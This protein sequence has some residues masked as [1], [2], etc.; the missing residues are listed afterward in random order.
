M[1]TYRLDR[2]FAPRSVALVGASPRPTSPGR[3]VLRNL[4]QAGFAGPIH[5]INPHY[6]EIEGVRAVRSLS[7]L[8]E[9]PDAI[10]IAAPP[11]AVPQIVAEA[12]EKGVAAGIIITSGLGHGPGSLAAS[13]EAAARR[14]GV[15]LVGPNCLGVL[16]P[17][18]KLN[19]SFAASMPSVGDLALV[20]QSGAIATGLVEWAAR[21][22]IGFSTIVSL[23]D[24][25]DVD[26]GDLL[27]YFA[28]DRAT[29]AILLYVEQITDARKFMTAARAAARA[30]PVVVVKS[31]RNQQGAKAA[32]THTGA[33]AGSDAV[34]DAAF[35]RAGLLR[36]LGLD[37]LFAAAEMLGQVRAI[38]GRRLA[39]LTNGGGIGVLAVDRL[40]DFGGTLAEISPP[41]MQRLDAALP[42]IWSHANPADISGDADGARYETALQELLADPA[43]DAIL[44]MNVPTALASATDAAKAVV[45][46]V[47]RHRGRIVAAK[48]VF[49]V[50]VGGS[51][52]AAESF[53]RAG[54]PDFANESDAVGGF[55]HLVRYREAQE[56]LLATPPNMPADFSPDVAV[57]R[58][59]IEGALAAGQKWLD[60][61]AA[62]RLL[63]AYA[64]PA[65]PAL[66]ARDPD[67]AATIAAPLIEGGSAVV[68]KILSPD[69]VHKS[70]VG[71]VRLNLASAAAVR[72]AVTQILARARELMPQARLAGVTVHPMIVRPKARELIAGIADD[73]TFGPVIVFGCGGTAVE[74]INDKALALPPLDLKLASDLI[75]RTRVSRILRAYRDVPA[76][77]ERAVALVLVKLAQ[78][79]ADFPEIREVDLNPFLADETGL[80]AVDTRIAL[81]P[82]DRGKPGPSGHPRFAIRPYPKQWERHLTLPDGASVFVRPVRP[83]DEELYP[84][85][86][87][88]VTPQDLRMR[89]FAPVKE[90]T[91]AFIVRFTQID[92]AR[93]MAFLAIEESSGRLMG[94]VRLHANANYDTGE[95]AI[96]VRSDLKGRGLGWLLMQ[97]IIEYAQSEGIGTIEGQVLRENTSMLA[98]C[99]ELGFEVVADP[100][101]VDIC[102]ARLRVS[103]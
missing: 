19:A 6:A 29:R 79:A 87:G 26:F 60:P 97:M 77:D 56:T 50:W 84:P 55:M 39:I 59:L 57:A 21:R 58:G 33:L 95:Y 20:S 25:I 89:F 85:F 68:V 37:E 100:D 35:R 64:I 51:D 73:P 49:A 42:P 93:A 18:A 65:A 4:R 75:A 30:K 28:L 70:D 31:G 17:G 47:K 2:L 11:H 62:T 44:V 23:G 69:I 103:T 67:E 41:T 46:V 16:V 27:D 45:E 63:A 14:N 92:Y 90:F 53:E 32:M 36:V 40:A 80:I 88:A 101:D 22:T 78:L 82:L 12:G 94:V 13:T 96:L 52:A 34:Y 66:L 38:P 86:F 71:G 91:H 99:R 7:D 9:P 74:V 81:A 83:E 48:P 1:S 76:V 98:M 3:A 54:I 43:N 8:T 15:R 102:T 10:V 24:G 72:E 5:L 61:V